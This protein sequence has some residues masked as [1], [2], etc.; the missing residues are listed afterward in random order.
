MITRTLLLLVSTAAT[1]FALSNENI[2]QQL[3]AAPGGKLIVDVDFGT[4]DVTAGSDNKVAVEANRKIDSRDEAKEKEY[5][6]AVPI[7]VTKEGNTV[8]IRARRE[9]KHSSWNWS[10]NINMDAHYAV[11]VPKKFDTDLRTAGGAILVSELTGTTKADT[12][13]GKLKFTHQHGPIDGKTSGGRID[14]NGCEGA[15]KIDTSGGAIEAFE[16]SG[17]LAARTSGGSIQVHNFGGDTNVETS[18]GGLRLE[19]INGKITGKTSGGSISARVHAPVPGDVD[20][21]TSAGNIEMIVSPEAAFDIEAEAN[22]GRVVS[23]LP[24]V[25]TRTDRDRLKA[26]LNGGGKAMVLR[27]GAGSI[28]IKASPEMAMQ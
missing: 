2:N 16:G 18:G 6:A 15:L 13:G 1:A 25:G 8:T 26:K 14:I 9:H 19:N 21:E 11:R 24:F 7:T 5:V 12:S 27:S 10:G 28:A 3:D 4:I 20:L 23:D 17:S 22:V